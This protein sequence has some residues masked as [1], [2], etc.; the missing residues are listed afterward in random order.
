M[1]YECTSDRPHQPH[2]QQCDRSWEIGNL[3]LAKN[4]SATA[5]INPII[6]SAIALL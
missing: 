1:V 2:H 3:A 6:K 5:Q 4:C